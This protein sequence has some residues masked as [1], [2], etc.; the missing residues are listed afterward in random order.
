VDRIPQSNQYRKWQ[1]SR[2]ALLGEA[3]GIVDENEPE[4]QAADFERHAKK[5]YP[6]AAC[7]KYLRIS[8][9]CLQYPKYITYIN[10]LHWCRKQ[11]PHLEKL[12]EWV[13]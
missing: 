3:K 7:L 12:L 10:I 8:L 13:S 11:L 6:D 1:S 2:Q 9:N 5:K 4:E